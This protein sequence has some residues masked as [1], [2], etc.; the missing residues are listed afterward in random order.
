MNATYRK[1]AIAAA[2]P[3]ILVAS[4]ALAQ[5]ADG[6]MAVTAEVVQNC[7]VAATPMNFG[8]ITEVGA[9][10]EDAQST[11]T[12][13]CT[14]LADYEIQLD[15]GVNADGTQ[16]RMQGATSSEFLEYEIYRDASRTARW[17]QTLG[18]DTRTGTA[19]VA[20]VATE[21]AYGRIPVGHANV[22]GDIYSDT[23]TVTV[24]F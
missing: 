15:N 7:T 12:L 4:P 24:N 20:G 16:R 1:A 22:S 23:I 5:S 6:S 3:T 19:N 17:G 9:A 2:I 8:P 11:I 14:A 13:A 10:N 18:T 21:T